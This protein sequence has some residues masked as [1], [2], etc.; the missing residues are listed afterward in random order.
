MRTTQATRA[1]ER[2]KTRTGNTHYSAV[3]TP[4]DL[5]YLVDRASGAAQKLCAPLSLDDFVAFV[6]GLGPPKPRKANKLDIA[7]EE[8]LKTS[9]R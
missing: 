1:V 6:D 3:A 8:Q 5:F 7:F 9:K 4:G 2:L